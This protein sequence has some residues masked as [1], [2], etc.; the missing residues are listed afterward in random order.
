MTL[1]DKVNR[2]LEFDY[3]FSQTLLDLPILRTLLFI[4]QLH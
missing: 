2:L 1:F 4:L 3:F